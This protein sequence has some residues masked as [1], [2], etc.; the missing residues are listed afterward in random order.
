[1]VN[2]WA[3]IRFKKSKDGEICGSRSVSE[4][5]GSKLVMGNPNV[6]DGGV[7]LVS[8]NCRYMESY[9]SLEIAKV[10]TRMLLS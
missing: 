9:P 10:Q 5:M 8:C 6:M 4:K 1:V 2:R 3:G 7:V